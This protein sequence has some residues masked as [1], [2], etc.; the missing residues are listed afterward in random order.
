M[1]YTALLL[2]YSLILSSCSQNL[3]TGRKQLSLVSEPELQSLAKSE[4]QAFLD[5]NKVL[6]PNNNKNAEMVNRAGLRIASAIK[7]FYDNKG[8]SSVLEGYDWKFNLVE[9]KTANAWCMPGGKVVVYTGLLDITQTEAGLAIV[10]GHEIAHAVAQH[11]S[12]RMSQA[13]LQQLGGNALAVALANKPSE[14]QSIFQTAY[15]LGSTLGGILPF[16]RKQ[17][18]EA[19]KYGL[20]FA[21]MAGYDPRVSIPLWERM[22]KSGGAKEIAFLS[23]HPSDASRIANMKESMTQA[24]KYYKPGKK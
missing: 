2:I 23:S 8:Q 6:N 24:M 10:L 12:E 7:S 16:S 17:E 19:D 21:A 20:Y 14:T 22:A 3:V 9:D 18:A 11:G 13:L 15:G 1:R 5:E 4:Y